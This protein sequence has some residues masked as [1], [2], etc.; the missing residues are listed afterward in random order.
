LDHYRYFY[1]IVYLAFKSMNE[2][3]KQL[4]IEANLISPESNGFDPTRL[5]IAQQKFAE[6]IV[7]EC[8]AEADKQTIYCRGI[9][10][11][12]WI[13]DHFEIL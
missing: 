13:K 7:R 9:P 8:T 6:L 3:I 12:K 1:S 4:A 2:R 5:S 11:G 10:W